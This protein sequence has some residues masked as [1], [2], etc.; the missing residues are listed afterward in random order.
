[1]ASGLSA[2]SQHTKAGTSYTRVC[3]SESKG[4]TVIEVNPVTEQV[5]KQ[6]DQLSQMEESEAA[7]GDETDVKSI[8]RLATRE[9]KQTLLRSS[10]AAQI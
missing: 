2:N 9:R 7:D 3:V 4:H 1:M 5:Q 8:R 6:C 10:A